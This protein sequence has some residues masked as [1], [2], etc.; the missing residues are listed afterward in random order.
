M[1]MKKHP[2]VATYYFPNWHVDKFNEKFHGKGWTEWRVLQHATPRF[3][4]HK[5]PKVPLWGYED[6]ADPNVMAKKI[7]TAS[8]HGIDAFIFDYYWFSEGPYRERCLLEGFLPAPNCKDIKFA[9]MWANH[10]P[11]YMHPCSYYDR[12]RNSSTLFP[13]TVSP[14]TFLKCT[15]HIIKTYFTQPNYLRIDGKLYFSIYN[16]SQMIRDLGGEKTARFLFDDFRARVAAAGLGELNLDSRIS[17]W[18]GWSWNSADWNA[19]ELSDRIRRAGFDMI[20]LYGM[21]MR[22]GGF[23]S[24]DYADW[25]EKN[26]KM[27]AEINKRIGIPFNPSVSTGWDV[28]PRTVQSDMY[29]PIG[30]PFMTVVV[31]S[32]PELFEK[33]FRHFYRAACEEDSKAKLVNISCWNEWTEGS[34]LEPCQEYG[35][36]RLEAVKRVI[37]EN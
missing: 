6:E 5:Q 14:E 35:Y 29:D 27:A 25:I 3:P 19:D 16:P 12:C 21:G 9:L 7:E 31:N 1:E 23:P 17:A 8:S 33:A 10:D 24:M 28:S 13:G 34:Y 11:V 36:A 37:G 18:D 26:K 4:G 20:C 30:Y 2:I 15:D 22:D 32:T